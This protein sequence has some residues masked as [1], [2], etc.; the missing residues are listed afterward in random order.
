[1]FG[2]TFSMHFTILGQVDLALVTVGELLEGSMIIVG[3]D[4]L[5]I[6]SD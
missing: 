3:L 1:M 5:S 2:D 4:L 6:A